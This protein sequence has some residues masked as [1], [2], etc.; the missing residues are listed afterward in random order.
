MVLT[1]RKR[2]VSRLINVSFLNGV[3]RHE[4][5]KDLEAQQRKFLNGVCRH[6]LLITIQGEIV[7][8]LNGVCRHEQD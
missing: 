4:Q 2:S 6:E 1:S 5:L 7:L 8:F 3:C